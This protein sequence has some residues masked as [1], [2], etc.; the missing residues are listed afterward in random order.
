MGN[1]AFFLIKGGFLST[2]PY[3]H[4]LLIEFLELKG[5]VKKLVKLYF[6][7][8]SFNFVTF[9]IIKYSFT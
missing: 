6:L 3:F 8:A 9:P 7:S 1:K 2:S 4:L 5:V